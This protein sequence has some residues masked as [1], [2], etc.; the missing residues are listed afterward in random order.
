MA[1]SITLSV[2]SI[3]ND[4]PSTGTFTISEPGG[5]TCT[6]SSCTKA[7]L[8]SNLVVVVDSDTAN[9]LV[10][11]SNSGACS[12]IA[13]DTVTWTVI[14]ST[15]TPTPTQA[16]PTP[17]PT[18]TPTPTPTVNTPTPTA[19]P[20][21]TI[22]TPTPTPTPTSTP[23]PTPITDTPT[24]TP[25]PTITPN[26]VTFT[27]T[28]TPTSTP[29]PTPITDTPTPTPTV[30]PNY[31]SWIAE[32]NDGGDVGYV[33]IQQGYSEGD[34]V[35][36]TDTSF[37]CWTLGSL[38]TVAPT[39]NITGI[40]QTPTPTG[41]PTP[42]PGLVCIGV[43]LEYNALSN[44][45]ECLGGPTMYLDTND[46]CT[47]VRIS[48]RTDCTNNAPAG[49]YS[50]GNQSRQWNGTSFTGACEVTNCP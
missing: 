23:T 16:P 21:P 34:E 45:F 38:S 4:I 17:T 20:T 24:P 1:Q 48:S 42:T 49:W 5:A 14:N 3:S 37:Q 44:D 33:Q 32:R 7:Q 46:L 10:L 19:T 8:Q 12:G 27:P 15:P 43:D 26:P 47:A 39:L 28:P 40:C 35:F 18:S 41:T 9:S 50:D 6:P 25:T 22:N 31:Q 13:T 29:T 11:T 30:T 36:V 2:V